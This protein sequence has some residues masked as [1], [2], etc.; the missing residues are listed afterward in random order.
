MANEPGQA[1][2]TILDQIIERIKSTR[3]VGSDN[4]PLETGFVYSQLVLGQMVDPD[5]FANPWSPAGGSTV[6]DAL[7]DGK[8]PQNAGAT[9]DT[10]AA[11]ADGSAP[12][13][14]PA[15]DAAV[16][17]KIRRALQAA[18]NTSQLV[19]RLIMVTKDEKMREYPGGGR[20][21]SFAYEG[22]INGM[23]PLPAP[24]IPADVQKRLDEAKKVLYEFDEDGEIAGKSKLYKTYVKNARAYAESKSNFADAQAAALRDPAKAEIW[25]MKSVSLQNAVDEA[26]DTLKTEGAEKVEKALGVI[27]SIG[28]SIQDRMIAKARKLLDAWSLGLSGVPTQ[29]PYSSVLPSGWADPDE[30]MDGW[31]HLT[32]DRSHYASHS[33]QNSHFF[34]QS[35]AHSDSSSTSVQTSGSYFGFGGSGG[36]STSSSH[37][38]AQG[39]VEATSGTDFKNDAEGLSIELEYGLCDIMRPWFMGDLYYMKNWYLVNNPAKAISD[40]T[41]ESQADSD[42]TLMPMVPMQF[43]V[44]RNVKIRATKWNSDGKTLETLYGQEPQRLE[45]EREQRQCGCPC[46]L[47]SVQ[48]RR[49]G[50]SLQESLGL[51]PVFQRRHHGQQRLR[52]EF[53]RRDTDDQR[54]SDRGLALDHRTALPAAGR[55]G[56]EGEDD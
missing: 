1:V 54:R 53:R 50:E 36:G 30:D 26:Y 24:P 4:K 2:L 27:E 13:P 47:W 7:K 20:T 45:F 43:L 52:G 41:I 22:I 51:E 28:V 9:V 29:T 33:G 11:P 15:A 18:F 3:P 37:N 25:P 32:V 14:A 6:N 19:D 42:K 5:D 10:G 48:L 21:I 40:G 56:S 12:V 38:N 34:Q 44:V 23:Q 55:S 16:S 46:R 39:S 31:Y 8:L 49:V 35:S 17:A